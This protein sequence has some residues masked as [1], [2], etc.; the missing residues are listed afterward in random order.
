MLKLAKR[1]SDVTGSQAFFEGARSG[2]RPCRL[3]GGEHTLILAAGKTFENQPAAGKP[4]QHPAREIFA[5][6]G[7]RSSPF[8]GASL[9][10]IG[11][12]LIEA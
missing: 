4:T 7:Q 3:D 1:S 8:I 2:T 11:L 9:L 12:C 10:I 5:R 6:G